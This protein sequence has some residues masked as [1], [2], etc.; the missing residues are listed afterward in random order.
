MD[1]KDLSY[2]DEPL[3]E[4]FPQV[5]SEE[6]IEQY[7]IPEE[8]V[9]FYHENGYVRNVRVL[10]DD[11][12]ERLRE[13][14][15]DFFD[16]NHP[17]RELWYE[18]HMDESDD[19]DA[20][21][22]HSLG[23]WRIKEAFHDILWNPAVT[24]PATQLLGGTVRLWHDQLFC[25]PPHHGGGVS[26][27]QDYSY[28]TRTKPINHLTC[29]I[30]LDDSTEENGCVQ[31][32]PGTHEWELLPLTDLADNMEAIKEVL[33]EEQKAQFDPVPIEMEK[34]EASFHHPLTVHGSYGNNSDRPRRGVVINFIRDGV[35]SDTNEPLLEGCPPIPKGE[36]VQGR[37]HPVLLENGHA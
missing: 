25:K 12:V 19:P 32:V 2:Y 33:T 6:E 13:E 31:Y 23:A 27:H 37:F 3:T 1:V 28:W 34:G 30:G 24:V 7:K 21:L 17:G 22:F 36:T 26:W 9:E 29:W 35:V 14:L 5:E 10:N 16:E 20:Q 11:Q 18:F 4:M 8:E 15:K